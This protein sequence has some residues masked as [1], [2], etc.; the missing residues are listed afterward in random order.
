MTTHR[1]PTAHFTRKEPIVSINFRKLAGAS[2]LTEILAQ[3]E[4]D[5][6]PYA[7]YGTA[8]AYCTVSPHGITATCLM[9]STDTY[10][11]VGDHGSPIEVEHDVSGTYATIRVSGAIDADPIALCERLLDFVR[12]E[13]PVPA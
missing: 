4:A 10:R 7:D 12:T 3:V 1:I 13:T 6:V 8:T 2:V 5:V 9:A 11:A